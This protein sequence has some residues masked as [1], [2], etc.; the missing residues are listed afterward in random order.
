MEPILP[1]RRPVTI[2]TIIKLHGDGVVMCKQALPC[3]NRNQIAQLLFT[4]LKSMTE[5]KCE[6]SIFMIL[7]P[8]FQLVHPGK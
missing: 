4:I 5:G 6:V 8:I 7:S 2:D 1:V 3:L